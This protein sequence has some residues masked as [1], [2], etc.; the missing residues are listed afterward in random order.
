MTGFGSS[1]RSGCRVE[2]RS[3]NQRFLEIHIK[4]PSFLNRHDIAFRN[5]IRKHFSR[6]KFD[7]NISIAG[8]AASDLRVNR[9][10]AERVLNALKS[11]KDDLVLPGEI[12][13]KTLAGFHEMF[14]EPDFS[15]DSDELM[16]VF[17]DAVDGLHSMRTREGELLVREITSLIDSLEQMGLRVRDLSCSSSI[18]AAQR[19]SEKVRPLLDSREID[20]DRMHQEIALL[21][22]KADISEEL[23]RLDCHIKQFRDM[24]AGDS[25]VG[26][27]LDFLVQELNREVNTISSKSADYNISRLTVDM[28]TEIE[29]IREQVQ[30]L[31]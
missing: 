22:S 16:K 11:L 14:M 27:K 10:S 23:A 12:D 7:V 8:D 28:K 6:G 2:I 1:E 20:Q 24:L 21:A 29:K 13:I 3:L 18:S 9:A 30:N 19:L 15:F 4:A 25:S 31:Q 5:M 26:R 17:S